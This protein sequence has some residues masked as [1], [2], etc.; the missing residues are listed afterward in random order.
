MARSHQ[1]RAWEPLVAKGTQ[2]LLLIA[3]TWNGAL[4]QIDDLYSMSDMKYDSLVRA[5]ITVHN[6][7]DIPD[8]LIPPD[9]AGEFS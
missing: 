7:H 9:S 4:L 1:G 2:S 6:R 3:L 5:G 8:Y